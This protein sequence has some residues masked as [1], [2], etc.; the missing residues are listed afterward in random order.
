MDGVGQQL[1]VAH[2][3]QLPS[4]RAHIPQPLSPCQGCKACPPS[5]LGDGPA[6]IH[7]VTA[8]ELQPSGHLTYG[9]I[10]DLA[11]T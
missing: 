7:S 1:A 4:L 6:L 10:G 5:E 9:H 2:S 3:D 11:E 8:L